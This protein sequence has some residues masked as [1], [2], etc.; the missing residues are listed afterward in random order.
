MRCAAVLVQG[1]LRHDGR[2]FRSMQKSRTVHTM[3][4]H[5]IERTKRLYAHLS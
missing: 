3:E 1:W 5:R 2:G 4:P